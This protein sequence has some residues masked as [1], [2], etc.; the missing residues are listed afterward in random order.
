LYSTPLHHEQWTSFL[1]LLAH[2]TG[3]RNC[4]LI[5]A[6]SRHGLSVQ[7]IGGQP[8]DLSLVKSYN[9]DYAPK[10]PLRFALIRS[11]RTGVIDCEDLLPLEEVHAS[12]MFRNINAPLGYRYPGLIALTCTLRRLECISIWR[13]PEEGP[14]SADASHLLELLVPHI[15]SALE[16][17]HV[18]GIAGQRIADA[19]VIADASS[20][21]TF[22]LSPGGE[23]R[24]SNA[25]A[26]ALLHAGD[27][28]TNTKGI[29]TAAAPRAR[30]ALRNLLQTTNT[31]GFSQPAYHPS[32][33]VSLERTSGGRPL[34][35]LASPVPAVTHTEAEPTILLL[36]TDPD[37]PIHLRDD[38]MRANFN[39][40][41]AETEVANGLLTGYTVEEIAALRSVTSG[42]IRDQLKSLFSKTTTTRQADL[43]RL[44]LNL[45]QP[46]STAA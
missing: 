27:G 46:P 30:T 3:S 2:H 40:T 19:E 34:Q 45:P 37:R 24:H 41:P 8:L 13:T 36:V 35:L 29:L 5:C 18:L 1:D 42:T 10:D 14:L 17:R 6:N 20:T 23:I 39:F 26:R 28:L 32:R 9:A 16:I 22:L 31:A 11:G 43:I 4:F 38:L 15:Q 12:E 21:A 33:A 25:A 7:A 44:L